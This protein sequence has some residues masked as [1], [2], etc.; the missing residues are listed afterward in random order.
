LKCGSKRRLRSLSAGA[1]SAHRQQ[2]CKWNELPSQL[3][4]GDVSKQ[5]F[6]SRLAAGYNNALTVT[7]V[8][9]QILTRIELCV[10][11]RT[12]WNEPR[13]AVQSTSSD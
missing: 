4:D 12:T 2:P 5:R 8:L 1:A 11:Q 7:F 6:E 9:L 13:V 10:F 3:K